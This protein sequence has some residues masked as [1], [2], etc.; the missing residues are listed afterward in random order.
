MILPWSE[1]REAGAVW[2]GRFP[3]E[4]E[5]VVGQHTVAIS[6]SRPIRAEKVR[7][8]LKPDRAAIASADTDSSSQKTDRLPGPPINAMGLV[9]GLFQRE[10]VM[11]RL[12]GKF[13][14][15]A[16]DQH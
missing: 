2:N 16:V 5:I 7:S 12:N 13:H 1:Q 15:F 11:Q 9:S 14:V 3:V 6:P 10:R 8:G 4:A